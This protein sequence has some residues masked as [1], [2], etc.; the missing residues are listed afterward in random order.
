MGPY[1]RAYIVALSRL[2][3]RRRNP[4]AAS[5]HKMDQYMATIHEPHSMSWHSISWIAA[6]HGLRQPQLTGVGRI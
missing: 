6:A 4:Q 2:L 3:R 5:I 1:K